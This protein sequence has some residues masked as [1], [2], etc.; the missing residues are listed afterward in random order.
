MDY[1]SYTTA[2]AAFGGLVLGVFNAW[3]SL[4]EDKVKLRITA[5]LDKREDGV[6]F[7]NINVTNMSKFPVAISFVGLSLKEG[8][9]RMVGRAHGQRQS[10]GSRQNLAMAYWLQGNH[11]LEDIYPRDVRSCVVRT[12]CGIEREIAVAL[13]A[14][15]P[16]TQL[17]SGL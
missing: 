12:E 4:I 11:E 2:V 1:L 17:G 15:A 13:S 16:R 8:S 9:Y 14:N 3:R 7:V 6:D 5:L 10:I